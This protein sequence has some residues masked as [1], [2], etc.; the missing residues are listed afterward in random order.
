MALEDVSS[1]QPRLRLFEQ[2]A[3]SSCYPSTALRCQQPASLLQRLFRPHFS[4]FSVHPAL[5]FGSSHPCV[6]PALAKSSITLPDRGDHA[7]Q[8]LPPVRTASPLALPESSCL[9]QEKSL[10]VRSTFLITET[11]ANK[12]APSQEA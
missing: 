8:K 9:G 11:L 6:H 12:P 5:T 7:H 4:H 2:V 3:V 10:Q 1:R